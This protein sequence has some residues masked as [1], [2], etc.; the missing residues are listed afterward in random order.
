MTDPRTDWNKPRPDVIPRPTPWPLGMAA[1]ITLFAWGLITSPIVLG[2]GGVLMGLCL[3]YW[4]GELR[5]E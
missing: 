4:I 1:G 5:H 2:A 3:I